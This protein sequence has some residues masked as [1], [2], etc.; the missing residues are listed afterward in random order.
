MKNR[1]FPFPCPGKSPIGINRQLIGWRPTLISVIVLCL[2]CCFIEPLSAQ[3]NFT[4]LQRGDFKI[5]EEPVFFNPG[6]QIE[7]SYQLYSVSR[8]KGILFGDPFQDILQQDISLKIQSRINTNLFLHATLGNQSSVINEQESAFETT[9]ANEKGD[10]SAD[11]GL[12][13]EFKEAYLEYRHNPNASLKLGKHFIHV[14]DRMGL[15]YR[16]TVIAMSQECRIGTWCYYVG[17]AR[18]GNGDDHGLFW[19]QLDYPIYQSGVSIPDPWS[20]K[21]IRQ[22]H[23]FNVEIFRAMHRANDIPLA[24]Y[25]GWTG[26]NSLY[27]DTTDDTVLGQRVYFDNDGIEYWGANVAWNFSAFHFHLSGVILAGSREYHVGTQSDGGISSITEKNTSG[28][29][30]YLNAGFNFQKEW[31]TSYS[32]FMSSGNETEHDGTKIW[33]KNSTAFFEIQKGTWGEAL[34]YFNG[35]AGI[36]DGHSATNLRYSALNF[37]FRSD[38]KDIEVDFDIYSFARTNPVFVNQVG[39]SEKKD[40]RI[41]EELDI[42]LRW[43]LEERLTIDSFVSVFSPGAA[44]S[45]N[46]NSR[47][48]EDPSVFSLGGVGIGYRF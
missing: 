45:V 23:S 2:V 37:S 7:G 31:S 24:E 18:L 16:G 15:I 29:A 32:Y 36:G 39:D 19:V 47:P 21:G 38:R 22:Q 20:E 44:Y 46:D 25:G 3:S 42:S 14:G 4:P 8:R 35:G 30:Y 11:Q 6:A 41:G 12:V 33:T 27:H 10:S 9:D 28:N 17:L 43:Y 26:K 40:D 48:E 13:V 5:K 1:P 34:I